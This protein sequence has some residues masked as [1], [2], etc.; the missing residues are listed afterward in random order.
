MQLHESPP[1][2]STGMTI[3]NQTQ[4]VDQKAIV[5]RARI[6]LEA[7]LHKKNQASIPLLLTSNQMVSQTI[8]AESPLSTEL[9]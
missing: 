3:Q 1:N 4:E 8:T 6:K 7:L 2:D 5:N 9:W